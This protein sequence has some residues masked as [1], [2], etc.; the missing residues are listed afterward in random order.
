MKRVAALY[1]PDWSIDRLRRVAALNAP[2]SA[3]AGASAQSATAPLPG[4]A[5]AAPVP[6][7]ARSASDDAGFARGGAA[8]ESSRSSSPA[9]LGSRLRGSTGEG[10]PAFSAL[11]SGNTQD[12]PR[13]PAQAGAQGAGY[14]SR[15][16][17]TAPAYKPGAPSPD[18]DTLRLPP[19][20]NPGAPSRGLDASL[21]GLAAQVVA[22]QAN[23]CSV[24]RGGGWRPGA[25]WAKAEVRA[26]IDAMPVHQRP[27]MRELG[28]RSEAAEHP[29]KRLRG[30]DGAAPMPGD[31]RAAVA[32]TRRPVAP[33]EAPPPVVTT[34]KI[35]SRV[36]IAAACPQARALGIT[37]G[38]A[39][40]QARAQT[41]G[42]VVHPADHDG[43]AAALDGLATMLARRVSPIVAVDGTQGLLIDVTGVAHLH[44]GER[45][46]AL[47]IVRQLA[48][49]GFR[50]RIAIAATPGAAHALARHAGQTITLADDTAAALA[51]LPT[52]GLRIGAAAVELLHRLGIDTIGALVEIARGPLAR[53][54][55]PAVVARLDQALGQVPEPLDPVVPDEPIAV[56]QRFAEPI[57]TAEAIEHWLGTLVPHLV[58]ALAGSGL[59]ARRIEVIAERVDAVAQR[60]RIGLA[61]PSRDGAHILR[62]L[63]RRIADIEPGYGIDAIT[64]HLRAAD[65]LGPETLG[66][67]LAEQAVPDL[68]PLVDTLATRG[69]RTWRQQPVESDVPERSA[70]AAA[71]L[72]PPQRSAP[73]LKADDVRRLDPTAPRHPWHPRWPRPVRLLRRP[74]PLD[75]VIALMPDG[76]PRRF[77]WRGRAYAVAR[78]DG[79]ERIAGEWWRRAGE[80]AAVRD[81]FCV[82]DEGGTRFWLY[83]RGD[84]ERAETGDRAWFLHGWFG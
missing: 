54:L 68:S 23:A 82:E 51:P 37:A 25:R 45:A 33:E 52:A 64:L 83:R 20:R 11:K 81:Y 26:A 6:A 48:R 73:P 84:G 34:H 28:R 43:D 35:G 5:E 53:R 36:E 67:A 13:A 24:P 50:A 62:L 59:G 41:P 4:E 49:R 75:N 79:P 55:G 69:N 12:V 16:A 57:A 76:A 72:D 71:P 39:L 3:G 14:R 1:L 58:T 19:A 63:V 38:M 7:G 18:T 65:P 47:R 66:P 80:R 74:E 56:A 8:P 40:T 22:E 27:P 15:D 44:G 31:D 10:D 60:I 17:S 78:A 9:A 29:F 32:G 46:M 70:A 42:L 77:V 2:H 61:R 21:A 30:D